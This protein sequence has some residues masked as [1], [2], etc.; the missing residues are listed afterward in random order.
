MLVLVTQTVLLLSGIIDM[1]G[2]GTAGC[3]TS[4][5]NVSEVVASRNLKSPDSVI[6]H[7]VRDVITYFLQNFHVHIAVVYFLTAN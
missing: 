1:S 6:Q 5:V 7:Q 4:I 3:I 2:D